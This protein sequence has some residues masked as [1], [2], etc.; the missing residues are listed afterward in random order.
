MVEPRHVHWTVEKRVEV[1]T[2]YSWIWIEICL[3]RRCEAA[4]LYRLGLDRECSGPEKH[5]RMLFQMSVALSTVEAE[6][7]AASV[8]SREAVWLWKLLAGL[9]HLELEATLI[10]FDNQSCVKHIEIKY[11]YI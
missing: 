10:Y 3:G 11:H 4:G 6:Y 8:A 2:W 9:F 7:I 1:G 5:I